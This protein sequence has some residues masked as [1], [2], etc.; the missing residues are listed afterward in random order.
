M[1]IYF[2]LYIPNHFLFPAH[3]FLARKAALELLNLEAPKLYFF[4]RQAEI[5]VIVNSTIWNLS[6]DLKLAGLVP[7]YFCKD[8]SD[9]K[10]IPGPGFK[11]KPVTMHA[12]VHP[13]ECL[14]PPLD[15][16]RSLVIG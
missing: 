16:F 9:E 8:T 13:E 4:E 12:L 10:P 14:T 7:I 2:P 5:F 11:D 3:V 6:E 1:S 15:T